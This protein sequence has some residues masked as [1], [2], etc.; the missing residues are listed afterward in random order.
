MDENRLIKKMKNSEEGE[1][2]KRTLIKKI[3]KWKKYDDNWIKIGL[4]EEQK[5]KVIR[6]I[7]RKRFD[8]ENWKEIFRK[9]TSK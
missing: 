7:E 9:T 5:D 4:K 2:W 1:G 8:E 3:W 6:K